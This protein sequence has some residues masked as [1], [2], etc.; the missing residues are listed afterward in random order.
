MEMAAVVVVA[1]EAAVEEA[2][3]KG[4]PMTGHA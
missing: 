2:T 1:T 3:E 4:W